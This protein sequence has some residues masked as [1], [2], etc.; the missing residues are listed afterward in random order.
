MPKAHI[1]LCIDINVMIK[2]G[3]SLR[4]SGMTLSSLADCC[5]VWSCLAYDSFDIMMLFSL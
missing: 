3:I 4:S 2:L 1:I 5:S